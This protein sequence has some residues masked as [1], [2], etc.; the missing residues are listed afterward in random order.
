MGRYRLFGI[1]AGIALAADQLTKIWARA[2]LPVDQRGNGLPLTVIE[3]YWDWVLEYNTGSAFS[4]ITGG[5]AARVILAIIAALALAVIAYLVRGARDDQRGLVV[6]LG[7]M[8]GGA[9]GNLIDR[10]ALGRVT[11]FVLWHVGDV[12]WPV[13]NVADVWLVI[14]VP[15]FLFFGYRAE[16]EGAQLHRDTTPG[17][18]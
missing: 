2:T 12:Y 15:L 6:A 3:G 13:F 11:D 8:A 1:V 9:V 14:A 18:E 16:K 7:L 5:G 17:G 10:I 4:L